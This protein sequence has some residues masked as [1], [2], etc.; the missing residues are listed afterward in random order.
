M[1]SIGVYSFLEEYTRL[2]PFLYTTLRSWL[3]LLLENLLFLDSSIFL[4][5]NFS[6]VE[7]IQGPTVSKQVTEERREAIHQKHKRVS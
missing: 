6:K 2:F 1:N 3:Q 5:M 4:F 7:Q